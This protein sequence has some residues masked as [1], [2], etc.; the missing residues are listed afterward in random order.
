MALPITEYPLIDVFV[1]SKDDNFQ[2]RPFLVKEEKLLVMAAETNEILD[3]VKA[4]QQIITNCSFG[5]VEGDKL[6]I[7]DMQNVF[8]QLRKASIGSDIEARFA[9]GHCKEKQDVII[10]LNN[11][12]LIEQDGHE[13]TIKVSD[14]MTVEMRYPVASEL[15]EIAGTNEHAEIYTVAAE[16]LDK[17]YIDDSVYEGSE[18]SKE[19]KLEFIENMTTDQFEKIRKFYET[20]PALENKIQF[21]C[22]AC[23]KENYTFMNGYFDFFA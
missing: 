2:F 13:K 16:C 23:G 8:M 21:T 6:P 3:M 15:K 12:E 5:K 14:T 19:D 7:F 9:C 20:M 22:K 4:S 1:Y 17:I 18:L 11:F 10:D